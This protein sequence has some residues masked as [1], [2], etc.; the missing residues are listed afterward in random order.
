MLNFQIHALEIE[1][2]EKVFCFILLN[3]DVYIRIL[4]KENVYIISENFAY[5]VSHII[6]I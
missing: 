1:S 4:F 3:L 5:A 6:R 2:H